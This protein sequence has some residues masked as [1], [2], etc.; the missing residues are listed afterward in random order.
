MA[1]KV[2]IVT[3]STCDLDQATVQEYDIK[4][5]P[6]KVIYSNNEEYLDRI[7]ISPDQIY[8]RM[9]AEIPTTSL[10]SPAQIMDLFKKLQAEGY[11]HII[12]IHISSGLSGTYNTVKTVAREFK[13]MIIE[14]IDSKALSMALGI[15]VLESAKTLRKTLSF[16]AAVDKAK[17]ILNNMDVYFVVGTLEYLKKGGRI[18]YVAG[19]IGEIMQI[20]PIISINKEGKYYT[21]DK[22]RG[23]KKSIMRLF[24]IASQILKE[25]SGTLAVMHGAAPEE[26]WELFNKIKSL[27]NV[28]NSYF[29]QVGPVIGV[30]AGPGLIGF[31]ICKA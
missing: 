21:Y 26:S 20:K 16:Q 24:D 28:N 23:R 17:D 18:G 12:S 1:E 10:P 6:L 27:P 13:N 8:Q 11:T 14:V 25:K 30:H 2:A 7:E 3:D 29:G 9:P 5:L 4:V 19:T 22:V 15:P 31:C